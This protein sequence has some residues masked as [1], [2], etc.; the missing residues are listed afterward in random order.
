MYT[1]DPR[2]LQQGVRMANHTSAPETRLEGLP[3]SGRAKPQ[4]HIAGGYTRSDEEVVPGR[5]S[6]VG[7][8]RPGAMTASHIL[9][10]LP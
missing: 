9:R 3:A 1:R 2:I 5:R 10:L 7:F 4:Q 6:E 8:P